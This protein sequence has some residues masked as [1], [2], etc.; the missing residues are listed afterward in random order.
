M[1]LAAFESTVMRRD[2][3]QITWKLSAPSIG[4]PKLIRRRMASTLVKR[5]SASSRDFTFKFDQTKFLGM[6]TPIWAEFPGETRAGW[7]SIQL[8]LSENFEE[9][10]LVKELITFDANL[11]IFLRHVEEIHIIIMSNAGLSER[12]ISKSESRQGED[13]I[14]RLR[15][16]NSVSQYL[17]RTYIVE[18]LPQEAKRL[19][20]KRT[21]ILLGFPIAEIRQVPQHVPQKVYAFLPV[22]DYGLK[23]NPYLISFIL[24]SSLANAHTVPSSRRFSPHGQP[25]RHREHF[26][27]ESQA[28]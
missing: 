8:Q 22:R 20:W 24:V 15:S 13:R 4:A 9:A 5:A 1:R 21:K 26:A 2:S 17:I 23:V 10:S 19:D 11:L 25:R 12:R 7:T 14:I 6:V 3:Q 18:G 27:V 28:T 16:G